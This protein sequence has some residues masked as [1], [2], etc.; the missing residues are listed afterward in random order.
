MKPVHHAIAISFLAN[1]TS[2]VLL[3]R[4]HSPNVLVKLS[5]ACV[6]GALLGSLLGARFGR[7]CVRPV[8]W[9]GFAALA[10]VCLPVVLVTY[11]FALLGS[12][13]VAGYAL[14]VAVGARLGASATED[15]EVRRR[16]DKDPPT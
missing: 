12:P 16:T 15:L 13:L 10:L 11:G 5:A 2:M 6:I 9:S 8:A 7:A 3:A 4:V 1:L 14:F